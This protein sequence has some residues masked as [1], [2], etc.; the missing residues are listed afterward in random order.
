MFVLVP[1]IFFSCVCF[2]SLKDDFCTL[3]MSQRHLLYVM[4]VF[5]TSFVRYICP[6]DIFY[7][8]LFINTLYI[9]RQVV[10]Y[11]WFQNICII[12]SCS[13]DATVLLYVCNV[14]VHYR[15]NIFYVI[16]VWF[17][18]TKKCFFVKHSRIHNFII[19]HSLQ[20]PLKG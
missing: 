20:R 2:G 14:F 8:V 18:V 19:F 5:K 9:H 17:Y 12:L 13:F 16:I 1:W 3:W 11:L 10:I 15:K 4:D 7:F 6:K